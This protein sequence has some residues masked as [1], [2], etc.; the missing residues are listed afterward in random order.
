MKIFFQGDSITDFARDRSDN[1]NLSGFTLM[2]KENLPSDIEIV[3][4]ACSGDTSRQ[5][6][7][8]HKDEFKKEKADILIYLIG[9][10]D[11][12]RYASNA[13]EQMTTSEEFISNVKEVIN[14]SREINPNLKVIFIEPFLTPGESM[15]FE[16]AYDLYKFNV[17]LLKENI[18]SIV[19]KYLTLQEHILGEYNK[20]EILLYD[21]VH[22]NEKGRE[23][24]FN[25]LLPLVKELI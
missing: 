1:H 14:Y 6:L 22:P 24:I 4:Y 13:V 18:P 25:S 11:V 15:V 20:G 9:I 23:F 5:V 3:N 16:K 10:N 8:R 7:A 12:W 17:S 21:G 2:I 19:D